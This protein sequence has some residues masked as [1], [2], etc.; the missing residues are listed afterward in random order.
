MTDVVT[1]FAPSPTG[2]LHLGHAHSALFGWTTARKAGGRFLLRIEDIDPQRCRPEFDRDLREDLAW[3]GLTWEEPVRRQSEH[4]DDYRAALARLADLG[5]VYPCF[6]TR[7]DIAAEIARAGHAPH[8]PDGPLYPGTCRGLSDMER[9]DRIAAGAAYAVRLD[10]GKAMA[11]TGPLRWHDRRRGWQDAMPSLLGDIVLARKD[12]PTSYHLA[13]TL[14]DHL[15]GVTLVTRGDDLFF[16]T[17]AHR[18][19]Q[20]LLRVVPPDYDH[21]PLLVNER[22]E[23]LAKRDNAKTLRSLRELGLTPA[24]VRASAGFPEEL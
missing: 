14:D 4:L 5:V 2:H 17:N 20:E 6:C 10:V 24:A 15:Q 21:H 13:V 1:R 8:G 19:L 18:L 16:A 11:M 9:Q 7:K 3:L 12:V 23:R 22:G